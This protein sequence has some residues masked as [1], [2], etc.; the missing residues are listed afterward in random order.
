MNIRRVA[1]LFVMLAW[2]FVAVAGFT[3][4]EVYVPAIG[5][6]EG[7]GGSSF[8]S[9]LYVTNPTSETAQVEI[10][11]LPPG[12]SLAPATFTDSIPSG[13]TRVYPHVAS[14][15][16][17]LKSGI[18]AARVRSSQKLLV[19][20]RV[21]EQ[22][23]VQSE[24]GSKGL[25]FSGV[26]TE[27]GIRKGEAADLQGLR[28]TDDYRYN[29]FFV[30]TTGN[31]V[32]FDVS[33]RSPSGAAVGSAS[34]LLQPFEQ[35]LVSLQALAPGALVPDVVLHIVATA[36]DGRVVAAGALIANASNDSTAFEMAFS[37]SSLIGPTGAQGPPGPTGPAG[38]QGSM[39]FAGPKGDAGQ[40]GPQGD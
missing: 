38:P 28:Q 39:G 6:V 19:T 31:S 20:A 1:V 33:V 12:G 27:F 32:A 40:Q 15:L 21:Y 25:S 14:S 30:E 36:G 13:L 23:A 10:S 18:G 37:T 5:K 29:V 3:A 24:S 8:D 26:P 4:N 16:F 17:G 9:T 2:C 7:A 35:R 34:L 11:F 22:S